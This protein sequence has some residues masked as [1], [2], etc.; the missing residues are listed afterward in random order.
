MRHWLLALALGAAVALSARPATAA[1]ERGEIGSVERVGGYPSVLARLLVWWAGMSD[2][3]PVDHGVTLYRLEYWTPGERG[4]L[5][6][7]SGLVA[8][9]RAPV[10]RGVVSWQ[11]GTTTERSQTPSAPTPDEGVVASLAFAGRGY[12]LAAPDYVGLGTST[13]LHPY[14]HLPTTAT[15]VV[16]LLTAARTLAEERD[17]AWPEPLFLTG[18]SQGG[19]ATIAAMRELERRPVPGMRVTAAA[20]IAGAFDLSGLSFPRALEGEADSSSLYLGYLVASYA[21][22]Y[23]QRP[24]SVLRKPWA[25]SVAGLFDGTHD[26]QAVQAGLPRNP[27]EMFQ[28][29]FLEDVTTGRSHWLLARLRENDLTE[30]TPSAPVRLYYGSLDVDVSPEEARRQA[31]RWSERGADAVAVDVGPFAHDPSVLEAAP[32][33]RT[34]FDEL[35]DR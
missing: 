29:A 14:Y 28:P 32:R 3:L 4:D 25:S 11:H 10:L 19:H 16:D 27:R 17:F 5:E 18:F 33:V 8:F 2:R 20:P 30:W 34:W 22:I 6:V 21:R 35:S 12:L 9:P 24:D 7:A 23:G 13:S 26:G 31:A 15:T 1:P